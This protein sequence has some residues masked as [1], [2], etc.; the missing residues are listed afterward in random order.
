MLEC[1]PLHKEERRSIL[2][3]SCNVARFAHGGVEVRQSLRGSDGMSPNRCDWP[4]FSSSSRQ[5]RLQIGNALTR[6]RTRSLWEGRFCQSQI[7]PRTRAC[8]PA[9]AMACQFR[10]ITDAPSSERR[11]GPPTRR[12][13]PL[14]PAGSL[15]HMAQHFPRFSLRPLNGLVFAAP[16]IDECRTGKE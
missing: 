15:W 5:S 10:M 4:H 6:Q 3:G 13:F 9:H 14:T 7:F 2:P 1:A 11:A 16:P 12:L 8:A